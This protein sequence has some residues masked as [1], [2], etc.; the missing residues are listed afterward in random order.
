MWPDLA[1][2]WRAFAIASRSRGYSTAGP[3]PIV[4]SEALTALRLTGA[5]SVEMLDAVELLQHLDS[6]WLRHFSRKRKPKSRETKSQEKG[7]QD[8]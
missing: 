5:S 6:V 2:V 3:Q 8:V 1:H 7:K 4:A